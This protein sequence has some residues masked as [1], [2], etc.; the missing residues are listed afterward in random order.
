MKIKYDFSLLNSEKETLDKEL[1]L[2]LSFCSAKT[3]KLAEQ[4]W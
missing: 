2:S 3:Q 1:N 4:M